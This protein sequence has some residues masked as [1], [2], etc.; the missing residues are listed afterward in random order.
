VHR[1]IKPENILWE[2]DANGDYHFRL[3]DFGLSNDP[4]VARTI[5]GTEPFMAPEV[6]NKK[7]QTKKVDIW[8]LFATIVWMRD[9]RF[10][11]E[12]LQ[13]RAQEIHAW[14]NAVASR[15]EYYNIGAM[16]SMDPSQRPSAS[17]LLTMLDSGMGMSPGSSPPPTLAGGG[18]PQGLN[19]QFGAMNLQADE[20]TY[21]EEDEV[22]RPYYEPYGPD[23]YGVAGDSSTGAYRPPPGGLGPKKLQASDSHYSLT[24][25]RKTLANTTIPA[26][27]CIREPRGA[28]V[29]RARP[30]VRYGRARHVHRKGS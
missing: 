22:E 29:W 17:S 6:F 9:K 28:N 21:P 1:D 16:A 25:S 14:L 11:R 7:K 15:P 4:S 18:L 3:A 27:G 5:A 24:A 2:Y 12:C 10:R 19:A 8:S 30:V 13:L 23:I 26:V 20:H